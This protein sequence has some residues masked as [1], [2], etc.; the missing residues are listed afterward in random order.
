MRTFTTAILLAILLT[1]TTA[2]AAPK[3]NDAANSK[4]ELYAAIER[5]VE[6][7]EKGIDY[8]KSGYVT[9]TFKVD[10]NGSITVQ[11]VK[12]DRTLKNH[13]KSQIEN[14][15]I[16]DANLYGKYYEIKIYFDFTEK[17]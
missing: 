5:I 6:F 16:K 2:F 12:G 15:S 17:F 9:T 7:P 8:A 13:V 4:N 11:K 14:I 3:S 1:A 10:E